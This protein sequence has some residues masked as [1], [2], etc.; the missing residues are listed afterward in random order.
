LLVPVLP[1]LALLTAWAAGGLVSAALRRMR[2]AGAWQP[3][4]AGAA[5]VA[6]LV[7]AV[8]AVGISSGANA[9][10][11]EAQQLRSLGGLLAASPR[12]ARLLTNLDGILPYYAGARTYVWDMLG[13]TDLHNA[14]HGQIFSPRFG[15]T[16]PGYD[17]S[18]PFDL[19]VSNSSWDFAL[20]NATLPPGRWLLYSSSAWRAVPLYVVGRA[21]GALPAR[22][23]RLCGC[24]PV[25]LTPARRRALLAGLRNQGLVPPA[26]LQAARLGRPFP[27]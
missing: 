15:R 8:A 4:A 13:L 2:V 9:P 25:A 6:A 18:R 11:Y 3:A 12:P 24:A 21:G 7:A 20:L 17:F 26:L 23:Q 27:A 10:E 22:V 19:F 16:D 1:L 5:G 14:E